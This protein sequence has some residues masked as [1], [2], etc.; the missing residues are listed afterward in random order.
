MRSLV[1]I[2]CF[3]APLKG[4]C[5]KKNKLGLVFP[6][7]GVFNNGKQYEN[8]LIA[9]PLPY[10]PCLNYSFSIQRNLFLRTSIIIY[11]IDNFN[12]SKAKGEG[13]VSK[14]GYFWDFAVCKQLIAT[15]KTSF[16]L[17]TGTA[18]KVIDDLRLMKDPNFWHSFPDQSISQSIGFGSINTGV[19]GELSLYKNLLAELRINSINYF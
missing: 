16:F 17:S 10:L 14:D 4:L 13:L 7:I 3:V 1:L 18:L 6:I 9:Q 19:I 5:I 8:I 11:S 15:K 2:I 12:N